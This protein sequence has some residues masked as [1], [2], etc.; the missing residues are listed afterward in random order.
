MKIDKSNFSQSLIHEQR[1]HNVTTNVRPLSDEMYETFDKEDVKKV[2]DQMN[3]F[4]EP[5]RTNLKFELH[6]KLHEYY[7]TVVNPI[8]D[9]VIREIPPKKLLDIYA[10]MAEFMGFLVDEKI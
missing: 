8:T 1:L 3:Q 7:I 9:E 6:D 5:V 2:V 10:A 4:V